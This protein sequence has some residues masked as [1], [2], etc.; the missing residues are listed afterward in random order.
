MS[1][2]IWSRFFLNYSIPQLSKEI[3]LYKYYYPTNLGIM[4]VQLAFNDSINSNPSSPCWFSNLL[5]PESNSIVL[6]R[7]NF[8][9]GAVALKGFGTW[10]NSRLLPGCD[11]RLML[12]GDRR[13]DYGE[14]RW[15]RFRKR[16]T[17]ITDDWIGLARDLSIRPDTILFL[18]WGEA[19]L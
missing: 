18:V 7:R 6:D 11:H 13:R 9:D 8:T 4:N 17:R 16:G 12:E 19:R 3:L 5:D 14:D 10:P 15:R 1:W 2:K